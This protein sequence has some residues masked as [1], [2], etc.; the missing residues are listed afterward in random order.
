[1]MMIKTPWWLSAMF[2][3]LLWRYPTSDKVLYLTFDDG[4]SPGITEKV[5]QELEKHQAKATFFVIG[6]KVKKYPKTLQAVR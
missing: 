4:P 6:Q 3:K 2:P 5:L 1:M